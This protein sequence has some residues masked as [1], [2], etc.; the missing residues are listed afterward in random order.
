MFT[1]HRFK[2]LP[3]VAAICLTTACVDLKHAEVGRIAGAITGT[4]IGSEISGGERDAMIL[5]GL[6][7]A[8]V[9]GELG[10]QLDD[11]D[12][13]LMS[14]VAIFVLDHGADGYS[15][16]W[17]NRHNR[18]YGHFTAHSTYRTANHI[19]CRR[20]TNTFYASGGSNRKAANRSAGSACRQRD[21]SWSIIR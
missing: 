15:K 18:H 11:E 1:K 5:G 17:R 14:G 19:E 9:G 2:H 4:F 3:L 6:L 21:G 16:S 20:F 13:V 8:Y 10:G 12:Y 7:G